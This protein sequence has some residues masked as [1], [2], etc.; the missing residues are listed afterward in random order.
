MSK[1]LGVRGAGTCSRRWTI[2]LMRRKMVGM[3]WK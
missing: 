2:A 1:A 3:G